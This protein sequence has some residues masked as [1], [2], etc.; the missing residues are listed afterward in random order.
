MV[1]IVT[2]PPHQYITI[3]LVTFSILHFHSYGQFTLKVLVYILLSPSPI[4]PIS[5]IL[6]TDTGI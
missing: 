4:L 2:P 6:I 3:L 5:P 1:I